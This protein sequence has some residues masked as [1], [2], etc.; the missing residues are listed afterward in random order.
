LRVRRAEHAHFAKVSAD[1]EEVKKKR[2]TKW[3]HVNEQIHAGTVQNWRVAIL[4]ADIML[5]DLLDT[6]GYRGETIADQ[7]RQ[8]NRASFATIDM[9][10]EAHRARNRIAHEAG[11]GGL[12][13]AEARRIISLY[14]HVFQEFDYKG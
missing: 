7:L 6:L 12:T 8:A 14:A 4:E 3:D 5:K 2:V 1:A 11:G 9:A 13:Q 10:W